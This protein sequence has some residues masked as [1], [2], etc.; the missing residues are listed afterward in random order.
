MKRHRFIGCFD[1]KPGPIC[2]SEEKIV[3]Q[4]WEV[5]KLRPPEEVV[6][7]DGQGREAEAVVGERTAAGIELEIKSIA[8][9]TS[10]P[11]HQGL[12]ICAVLKKKNF[13]MVCQKAVEAGATEII[14]IVTERT[15]KLNLRADRLEKIIREA[16]EQS[17][18]GVVPRL[19]RTLDMAAVTVDV[20]MFDD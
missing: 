11:T 15:I 10:E 2:I 6:L 14:P 12:L 3:H 13:E 18:R 8:S 1:L 19:G 17:G 20:A 7:C 4:I 5:L 9:N 16:A